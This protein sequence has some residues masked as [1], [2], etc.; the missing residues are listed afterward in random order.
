MVNVANAIPLSRFEVCGR[1]VPPVFIGAGSARWEFAM[2]LAGFTAD[3]WVTDL[4]VAR[5]FYVTAL[6]RQPDLTPAP[7]V[8]EWILHQAPQIAL[9]IVRGKVTSGHARIGIGT[10]DLAMEHTRLERALPAVPD[11]EVTPGV[12][13]LVE[14]RDPD[15]NLLVF[16]QDL[17]DRSQ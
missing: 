2:T 17:L 5:A 3:V 8:A 12:I 14:L 9:R 16:W 4:E 1:K 6:G 11:I 15:G 10:T 7:E 13:A